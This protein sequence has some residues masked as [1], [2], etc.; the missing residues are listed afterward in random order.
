MLLELICNKMIIFLY[1]HH[2]CTSSFSLISKYPL[3]G[4]IKY[5][6]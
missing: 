1:I 3:I 2:T 5:T 6:A 4:K